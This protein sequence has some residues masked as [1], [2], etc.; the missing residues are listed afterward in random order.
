MTDETVKIDYIG[1]DVS[2]HTLEVAFE[3]SSKTICHDNSLK[4]IEKLLAEVTALNNPLIIIEPTGGYEMLLEQ[5][6]IHT[7]IGIRSVL[8]NRIRD[9]A[10]ASGQLAKNDRIDANMI[11]LYGQTFRLTEN[12]A[13]FQRKNAELKALIKRREQVTKIMSQ[14]KNHLE[15]TFNQ[16]IRDN[17]RENI[18]ALESQIST[19]EKTIL[20]LIDKDEALKS[21]YDYLKSIN[22]VGKVLTMQCIS[23][24]PE[25]GNISHKQLAAL[26]GVVPYVRDSGQYLSLIHI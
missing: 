17:I 15:S 6:C 22:G 20:K 8:A 4:G 11:L 25:L 24:L 23:S 1:I 18:N 9:F 12:A 14:E 19:L 2:K 10:K 21:K 7:N 3:G 5:L 16:E 13:F 26:V